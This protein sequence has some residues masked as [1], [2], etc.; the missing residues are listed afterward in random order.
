MLQC[1][2]TQILI[3]I[4]QKYS[5]TAAISSAAQRINSF[6]CKSQSTFPAHSEPA[7]YILTVHCSL[8]CNVPRFSYKPKHFPIT[9]IYLAFASG[10]FISAGFVFFVWNW[11]VCSEYCEMQFS[12]TQSKVD[13]VKIWNKKCIMVKVSARSSKIRYRSVNH[14]RFGE[15]ARFHVPG[16]MQHTAI[17]HLSPYK[18]NKGW[19]PSLQKSTK[20][21]QQKKACFGV[22]LIRNSMCVWKVA[23]A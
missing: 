15:P 16:S 10:Q 22:F 12:Q 4:G 1:T 20:S 3:I 6:L 17:I 11:M 13:I 18:C 9:T 7:G 23:G 5:P 8:K 2:L 14:Y 19:L 21:I